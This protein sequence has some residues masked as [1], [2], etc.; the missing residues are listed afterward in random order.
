[1]IMGK[2]RKSPLPVPRL[3]MWSVLFMYVCVCMPEISVNVVGQ[4]ISMKVA[5]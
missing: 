1:M 5:V 2:T 3:G 4:C